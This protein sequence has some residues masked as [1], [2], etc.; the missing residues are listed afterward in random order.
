MEYEFHPESKCA[1]ALGN[2]C[3]KQTTGLLQRRHIKIDQIKCIGKESNSLEDVDAGS[4]HSEKT[5][6]TEYVDRRRDEWSSKIQPALRKVPLKLLVEKC[7][8][9]LSRRA[10][11]DLRAGRSRPHRK[12]QELLTTIVQ[13]L[14]PTEKIAFEP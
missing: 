13:Q 9:Q 6:Y 7:K 12:N 8:G 11:I 1:D 5:I 3:G 4:A 10:I 2:P 14:A